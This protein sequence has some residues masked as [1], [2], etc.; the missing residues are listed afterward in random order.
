MNK[1]YSKNLRIQPRE[2]F[3]RGFTLLETLMSL[4]MLLIV[5]GGLTALFG[6]AIRANPI[7]QMNVQLLNSAR[8]K[9]E[10]IESISYSQVGIHASGTASGPGYYVANAIYCS[11]IR[12]RYRMVR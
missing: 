5:L 7:D 9:L 6:L 3:D 1:R 2:R 4:T 11:P 12:L 8:A 10:Q